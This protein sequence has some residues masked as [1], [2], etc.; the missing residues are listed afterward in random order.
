M[1]D[2]QF[3]QLSYTE[4]LDLVIKL[5]ALNEGQ[6]QELDKA[7]EQNGRLLEQNERLCNQ[8]AYLRTHVLQTLYTN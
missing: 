6:R 3:F 2:Q 4:L 1:D 8:I 7:L 5:V